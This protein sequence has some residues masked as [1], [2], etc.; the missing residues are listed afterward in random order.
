MLLL[1]ATAGCGG[2]VY[3]VDVRPAAVLGC[4]VST[5]GLRSVGIEVVREA[6]GG[7][8]QIANLWS[9]LSIDRTFQVRELLGAFEEAGIIVEGVP[10]ETRTILRFVGYQSDSCLRDTERV[11]GITCPPI[12]V[13]EL[14][15]EGVTANFVCERLRE[16][17]NR[18]YRG[19]LNLEQ[20]NEEERA[21]ICSHPE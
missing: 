19:C 17:E 18:V 15:A 11:C 20:L 16:E 10:A 21:N 4:E 13:D 9:C 12:R 8:E 14:P 7:L 6:G 1:A 3:T 2:D 5:A